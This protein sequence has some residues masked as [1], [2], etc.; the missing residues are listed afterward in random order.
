MLMTQLTFDKTGF[1]MLRV[2]KVGAFHLWPVTKCQFKRFLSETD[3]YGDKWYDSILS[4][5]EPISFE[6]LSES[7]YERLFMTGILPREA[8]DFA[9]WLG[10]DF[11]LPTEAEWKKFYR[12]VKNL[13]NIRLSPYGLS[14]SAV[15]L[16]QKIGGF[17]RTPLTFSFLQGGVVEW[18]KGE[19]GYVGRGSPRD[20]FFPNAWNPL[21]DSIHAIDRNE[22]IFYFGFRLIRRKPTPLS[23]CLPAPIGHKFIKVNLR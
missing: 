20:S 14:D 16:G 18:L 9:G 17:L 2:R 10:E 19:K 23:K 6:N 11:D 5:N 4:L 21:N 8:M 15:T 12:T 3:Q 1:P 7:N 22:R 13:F